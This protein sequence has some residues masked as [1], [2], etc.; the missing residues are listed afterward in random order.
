MTM[1]PTRKFEREKHV[2]KSP[3]FQQIIDDA[4]AFI[5][6]SPVYG[7]PLGREK[8]FAG[9]GV[10]L[11]Y[12]RGTFAQ[13]AKLA[14]PNHKNYVQPIYAGKAVPGGWR[15]AR[16]AKKSIGTPLFSRL[17]QHAKSILAGGLDLEHFVCRFII[18]EGQEM[19]LISTV[20]AA[21]IQKY[22]PLWNSYI[23]G[24]GNHDPGKGRRQQ[25][26]SEWD[27][28]HPGRSWTTKMIGEAPSR[29]EIIKKIDDA[30]SS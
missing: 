10:Y 24:F 7:L 27:V 5:N 11:L 18:L 19:T 21:L 9:A 20:E 6:L 2:F 22:Q 28:L 23:D 3:D 1:Q 16:Q 25:Q 13:Y 30:L 12:Y 17:N 8:R 26:L 14:A 4:V 29:Y 15:R